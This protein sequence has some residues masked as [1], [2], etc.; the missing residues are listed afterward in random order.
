MADRGHS[1][2]RSL[3]YPGAASAGADPD[4]LARLFIV[5]S[6]YTIEAGMGLRFHHVRDGVYDAGGT[7]AN[8]V[9]ARVVA[10]AVIAH[11]RATPNW[12]ACAASI[13]RPRNSSPPEVPSRSS[14]R[15]WRT[16]R[17]TSAM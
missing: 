6:P 2:R 1:G 7:A 11:V 14:S 15:I 16:S 8:A 10:E 13:P 17:A 12:N 3:G 5:P 9:E 4:R